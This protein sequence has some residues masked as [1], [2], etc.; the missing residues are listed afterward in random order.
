MC[1]APLGVG[2]TRYKI[3]LVIFGQNPLLSI[4]VSKG[5]IIWR[6]SKLFARWSGGV[7]CVN[8]DL[9]LPMRSEDDLGHPDSIFMSWNPGAGASMW[10][11][12]CHG[13]QNY[14]QSGIKV[15]VTGSTA[16]RRQGIFS[17]T[18]QEYPQCIL[19]CKALFSNFSSTYRF[20]KSCKKFF[21][22]KTFKNNHISR[23]VFIKRW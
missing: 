22:N 9:T 15:T 20:T 5:Q 4:K 8:C 14:S 23:A 19:W 1:P 2:G 11:V 18:L 16:N 13:K 3:I 12:N 7:R 10:S 6:F 21:K 17:I